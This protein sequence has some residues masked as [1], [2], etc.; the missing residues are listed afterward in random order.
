[1]GLDGGFEGSQCSHIC[2][3]IVVVV[4]MGPELGS[5]G[6]ERD[7]VCVGGARLQVGVFW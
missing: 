4:A 5:E 1:M 6:V 7:R 3:W 2:V